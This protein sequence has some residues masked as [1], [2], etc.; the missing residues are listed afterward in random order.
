MPGIQSQISFGDKTT[1][2]NISV[3]GDIFVR[4]QLKVL[5]KVGSADFQQD[6]SQD[7]PVLAYLQCHGTPQGLTTPLANGYSLNTPD[8]ST[9]NTQRLFLGWVG[10]W[11]GYGL[12]AEARTQ[13]RMRCFYFLS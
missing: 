7:N 1:Y 13:A 12:A 9:N 3:S 2:R 8:I 11:M 4:N 10:S 5:V 6:K